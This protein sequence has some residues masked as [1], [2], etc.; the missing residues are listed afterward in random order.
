MILVLL[1]S[2]VRFNYKICGHEVPKHSSS[3]HLAWTQGFN[4]VQAAGELELSQRTECCLIRIG[5]WGYQQ[6][7]H[8]IQYFQENHENP[9]LHGISRK[10]IKLAKSAKIY[11]KFHWLNN[12]L[13]QVVKMYEK[14]KKLLI[15]VTDKALEI[16]EMICNNWKYLKIVENS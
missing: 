4:Q 9:I 15:N 5:L 7:A 11:R 2:A 8:L 13:R 3:P 1:H 16:S 12:V 14:S 6:L 10:Y